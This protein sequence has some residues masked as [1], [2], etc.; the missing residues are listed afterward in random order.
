MIMI[1]RYYNRFVSKFIAP[2]C[3]QEQAR[4]LWDRIRPKFPGKGS[5]SANRA[6][7]ATRVADDI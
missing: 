6:V 5:Y 7:Q 3:Q 1:N 4:D 2:A